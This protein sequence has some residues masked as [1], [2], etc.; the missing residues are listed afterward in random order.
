MCSTSTLPTELIQLQ[1]SHFDM[2][3]SLFLPGEFTPSQQTT[4]LQATLA[5][6]LDSPSV[7]MPP[8]ASFDCTVLVPLDPPPNALPGTYAFQLFISLPL[9]DPPPPLQLTLRQPSW[10]LRSSHQSLSNS[11]ASLTA[12]EDPTTVVLA[13]LELLRDVGA[14]L[15]PVLEDEADGGVAEDECRVWFWL[16]S[17]STRQKRDDMVKWAAGFGLTGFVMA[18]QS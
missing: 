8:A 3:E 6:T 12:E 13:A 1:L 5:H 18:G 2:L 16:Q 7:S 11:L 14:A 4:A 9:S 10:L 15:I 17:L